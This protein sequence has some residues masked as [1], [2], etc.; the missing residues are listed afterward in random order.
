M[1]TIIA[2]VTENMT[3]ETDLYCRLTNDF[4]TF[5]HNGDP[6]VVSSGEQRSVSVRCMYM[7]ELNACGTIVGFTNASPVDSE[8]WLRADEETAELDEDDPDQRTSLSSVYM[9]VH[10]ARAVCSTYVSIAWKY[11]CEH[12]WTGAC[13]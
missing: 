11:N 13:C 6:N 8:S 1:N 10:H 12:A 9:A 4:T 2:T 3:I 5:V 7:V